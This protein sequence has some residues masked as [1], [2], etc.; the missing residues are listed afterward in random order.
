M[1]QLISILGLFF[2]VKL[3]GLNAQTVVDFDGNVYD[4]VTIGTQVW[5]KQN[6]N[7]SHYSDGT[8]IP[9]V[10][11]ATAWEA[12]STGAYCD[13]NNTPSNSLSYGKLYNFFAAVDVRNICPQD[14]HVPSD[15]EWC[16]L[17]TYLDSSANCTQTI[18]SLVAGGSLKDTGFDYWYNPNTGATNS[19]NFSALPGGYRVGGTFYFLRT[20][21]LWMSSTD[22]GFSGAYMRTLRCDQERVIRN[23]GYQTSG[24][25]IRCIRNLAVDIE[26]NITIDKIKV[27]P[28]PASENITIEM[29]E[30]AIIEIINLQGQIVKRVFSSSLKTNVDVSM[31]SCGVYV[32]KVKTNNDIYIKKF[33]KE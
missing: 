22:G 16:Q 10:T 23:N 14:W 19:S 11:D 26:E 33:I 8:I 20:A 18:E 15:E 28:N 21:G 17:I 4:T 3:S 30:N 1:K 9:N 5:M 6:L 29:Y 24:A 31:I 13:Y 2:L 32:V 27:Y 7:T 12:L 25:S